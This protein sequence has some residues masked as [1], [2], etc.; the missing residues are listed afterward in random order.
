MKKLLF[1]V[2]VFLFSLSF[3]S[4]ASMLEKNEIS[5]IS[6]KANEKPQTRGYWL[7]YD[8]EDGT[9]TKVWVPR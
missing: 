2:V 1:V 8:N 7:W 4:S 6:V 5:F 3:N 9:F